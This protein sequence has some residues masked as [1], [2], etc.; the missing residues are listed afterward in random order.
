VVLGLAFGLLARKWAEASRQ[1]NAVQALEQLRS[2]VF[3][4]YRF[5][6]SHKIVLTPPEPPLPRWLVELFGID[7]FFSVEE[8]K[9]TG[10]DV[11]DYHLRH[12]RELP[13]VAR[14]SI[15]GC[16]V[17]DAGMAHLGSLRGLE[18]LELTLVPVSASGLLTLGQLP[19][20]RSIRVSST[21]V[22]ESDLDDLAK[23]MPRTFVSYDGTMPK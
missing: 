1:R 5:D 22:R 15:S 2:A 14:L 4:S 6:A 3:Y 8:I 23:A 19:K 16:D 17:T 10:N 13:N 11:T 9:L 20:L 21:Y 12:I 7:F 18:E